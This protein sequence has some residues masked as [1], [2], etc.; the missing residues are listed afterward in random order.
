M[1]AG[2]ILK[3]RNAFAL[4]G[5]GNQHGWSVFGGVGLVERGHNL[6]DIMAINHQCVPTECGKTALIG[7]Q[8]K[9]VHGPFALPHAVDIN[10]ADEIV[11][12]IVRRHGRRFPDA[13]FCDL[14]VAQQD[15]DTVVKLIQAFAV[16]RHANTN[17]EALPE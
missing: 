1:P 12:L 3:K 5:L 7:F 9:V 6:F 14:S 8:V 10:N 17:G 15:I 4:K 13:A 2:F 16:Q 11:E